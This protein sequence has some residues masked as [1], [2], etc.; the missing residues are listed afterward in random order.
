MF[1]F[2]YSTQNLKVAYKTAE[3]KL[4][5]RIQMFSTNIEL[6]NWIANFSDGIQLL[7]LITIYKLTLKIRLFLVKYQYKTKPVVKINQ[8]RLYKKSIVKCAK[9]KTALS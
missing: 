9:W 1:Y 4:D 5:F 8:V 6:E 2:K 3:D 7:F